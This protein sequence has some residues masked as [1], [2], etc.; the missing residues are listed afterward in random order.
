MNYSITFRVQNAQKLTCKHLQYQRYFWG[1]TSDPTEKG[2]DG[3][4]RMSSPF[5][6]EEEKIKVGA[7]GK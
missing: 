2:R 4:G 1:Y 5:T 3:E 7:Y 6:L